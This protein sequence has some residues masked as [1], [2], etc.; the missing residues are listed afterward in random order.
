MEFPTQPLRVV[1]LLEASVDPFGTS[2]PSSELLF[3]MATS[4][5]DFFFTL[6]SALVFFKKI[7]FS[8]E[9]MELS[10]FEKK[11]HGKWN[12]LPK[13]NNKKPFENRPSQKG[14]KSSNHPLSSF[15]GGRYPHLKMVLFSYLASKVD[16][17]PPR[18]MEK[19]M[20]YGL[21]NQL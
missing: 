6:S 17:R 9:P 3:L 2:E 20:S 18:L 7:S 1:S 13:T 21:K 4:G 16:G 15:R 12:I 19:D 10:N 14:R 11:W 8:T 5:N